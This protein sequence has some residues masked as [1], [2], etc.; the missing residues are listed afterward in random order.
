MSHV[1]RPEHYGVA[2]AL[3]VALLRSVDLAGLGGRLAPLPV[4]GAGVVAERAVAG[5][6][7]E[8]LSGYPVAHLGRLLYAEHRGYAVTFGL[9]VVHDG[10]EH[11]GEVLL[12][13]CRLE[14]NH[15]PHRIA[16][17]GVSRLVLEHEIVYE[18]AL[19]E[20]GLPEALVGSRDVHSYLARRVSPEY[21]AGVYEA[22]VNAGLCGLYR[23]AEP[24]HSP[25]DYNEVVFFLRKPFGG[26]FHSDLPFRRFKCHL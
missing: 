25:S 10:I 20:I 4:F 8:K 21:G 3:I 16:E 26:P 13:F 5:G 11:E 22:Y 17:L 7:D 2:H 9:A 15:I 14:E 24:R 1:A 6:V 18:S 12:F 19:C 23:G